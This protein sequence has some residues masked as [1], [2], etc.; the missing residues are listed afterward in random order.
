MARRHITFP[1]EG[2]WLFGSLDEA[3][4]A[5]GLLLVS[6]GREIRS[7]AFA[8]QARL[9]A[10]VAAAGFPVLRFDRRGVGA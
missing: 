6:G 8:G 4:G 9:A 5:V 7:G 10:E 2:A 3:P 1:C